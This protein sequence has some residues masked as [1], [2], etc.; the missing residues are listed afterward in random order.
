MLHGTIPLIFVW[1]RV[2]NDGSEFPSLMHI[3][4]GSPYY[5]SHIA[6]KVQRL[7]LFISVCISQHL[8]HQMST[9]L[10]T[11]KVLSTYHYTALTKG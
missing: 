10:G 2:Q 6:A 5:L 11:S 8:W 3:A 9:G 7:L 4:T 1:I